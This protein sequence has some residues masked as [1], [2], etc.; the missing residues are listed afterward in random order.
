MAEIRVNKAQWESLPQNVRDMVSTALI[1]SNALKA[2][3]IIVGD[4]TVEPVQ[5][6]PKKDDN[7]PH[8]DHPDDCVEKCWLAAEM[9]YRTCVA[10]GVPAAAC[11]VAMDQIYSQCMEHCK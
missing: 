2:G 3:D 7:N 5:V 1:E 6:S 4:D 8:P 9:A 11:E 10:Q